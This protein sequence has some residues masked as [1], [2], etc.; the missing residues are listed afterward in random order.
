MRYFST[1][2]VVTV[3]ST[4]LIS[5][6]VLSNQQRIQQDKLPAVSPPKVVNNALLGEKYTDPFV[7][8]QIALSPKNK[9][10]F[11][12]VS[13]TTVAHVA[14][15]KRDY[16][17]TVKQWQSF[18]SRRSVTYRT[19]TSLAEL[20]G[21]EGS[22]LIL[23]SATALD[24]QEREKIEAFHIR[25]G[26]ILATSALGAYAASSE[27]IG[28]AY[29]NQLLGA[30]VSSAVS[31]DPN[32]EFVTLSG[33]AAIVAGYPAGRRFWLE[34]RD[35]KWLEIAGGSLAALYS[36]WARITKRGQVRAA[37]A[38]GE[39]GAEKAHARWVY[40]GFP[41]AAFAPDALHF[42]GL[43]ENSLYWLTR[44][45]TVT[46]A[47]WPAPHRSAYIVEMDTEEGFQNASQLA[48]MM[49][50][51][52]TPATF[53]CV[54]AEASRHR[55]VVDV[56]K[57]NHELAFHGDVHTSFQWEAMSIQAARI[58][59]M[60]KEMYGILGAPIT[61]PGFRA[62]LEEYDQN[63][64]RALTRRGFGHHVV[65]PDRTDAMLP[66]FYTEDDATSK[67][68]LVIIPRTQRDDFIL[69]IQ[70]EGAA[71]EAELVDAIIADFD[72]SLAVGGLGLL[73][74][75]SQHFGPSY[76]LPSAMQS[77]LQY[78]SHKRRDVWVTTAGQVS[79][80][81]RDR[82]R[83]D[84]HAYES[85]EA[86]KIALTVRGEKPISNAV[87]IVDTPHAGA[88]M[89]ITPDNPARR[90]PTI[91]AVDGGRSA[92]TF[93]D[94]PPGDHVFMLKLRAQCSPDC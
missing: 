9:Q 63:T 22:V 23:P 88:S 56:L 64:E 94:T 10:I 72:V 77:F 66:F 38:Y 1:V 59:R 91:T 52:N 41:E 28:Y 19:I 40:F 48:R 21:F 78:V 87:I 70:G 49:D 54:T 34:R 20:E 92:I 6:F 7:K 61:S 71:V 68:D 39:H 16:D 26:A 86:V 47:T 30:T 51:V 5:W 81:W 89:Q 18:F 4:V 67:K 35:E 75:H 42:D 82:A 80:W 37:V 69:P 79:D 73:S 65:D 55:G 11:L 32:V 83:F 46:K 60:E 15:H 50:A 13:P 58:E 25:G 3:I 84:V 2:P 33:R 44:A 53:Y 36:D 57:K 62:P 27:F 29:I 31:Q 90:P 45:V 74:V 85:P 93:H 12:Y 76:L 8:A 24:A 43:I 14:R 17:A